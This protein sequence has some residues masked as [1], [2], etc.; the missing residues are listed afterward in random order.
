MAGNFFRDFVLKTFEK[1]PFGSTENNTRGASNPSYG[2]EKGTLESIFTDRT[3]TASG[4]EHDDPYKSLLGR[5]PHT[6]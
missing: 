6:P 1:I 3:H 4:R 2:L 5:I